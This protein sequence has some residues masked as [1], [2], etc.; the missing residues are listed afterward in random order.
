MV[1]SGAARDMSS[2]SHLPTSGFLAHPLPL[3]YAGGPQK[4]N[5]QD[6]EQDPGRAG[7]RLSPGALG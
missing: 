7:A 3:A 4:R 2:S 1:Y 6:L 5:T